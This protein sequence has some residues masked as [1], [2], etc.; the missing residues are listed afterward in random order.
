[1][2]RGPC[3]PLS[4]WSA[5]TSPARRSRDRVELR[6]VAL[7]SKRYALY[8]QTGRGHVLR[9]PSEHGLGLYRAPFASDDDW[10]DPWREWVD[11]VWRRIIAEV[12]GLPVGDPPDSFAAPAVCHLPIARP[13]VLAPFAVLNEGRPYAAQVKPFGFLTLGHVDQLAALPAT[14]SG[15]T[16]PLSRTPDFVANGAIGVTPPRASPSPR[17]SRYPSLAKPC[18]RYYSSAM[19]AR[20]CSST[21]GRGSRS[22]RTCSTWSRAT[23]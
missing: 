7:S 1:M 23:P 20:T 17:S 10:V 13:A 15:Q 18:R 22:R 19:A 12:E 9:K 11:L 16:N 8:E 5:R 2:R 6:C 4:S 21:G 3:R 14:V